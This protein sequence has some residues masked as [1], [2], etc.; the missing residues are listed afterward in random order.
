LI[1]NEIGTEPNQGQVAPL[2]PD[3]FVPSGEWNQVTESFSRNGVAI[4]HKSRNCIL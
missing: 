1:R 4:V 2:L 3:D